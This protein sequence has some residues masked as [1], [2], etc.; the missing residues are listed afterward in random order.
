MNTIT[1][2]YTL[3]WQLKSYPEYQFTKCKKCFNIKTGKKIKQVS[4]SNCIGYNIRGKFKSLHSL[5]NEI[6][7]IKQKEKL[8]F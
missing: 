5:R 4:Q 2:T 7:K 1:I 6:I 8:P 3:Y